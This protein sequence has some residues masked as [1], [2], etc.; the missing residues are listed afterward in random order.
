MAR[1]VLIDDEERLLQTLA[2][3]LEND[4]HEVTRGTSF[5]QVSDQLYPGRFEVLVTDIVMPEFDGM[6]VLREVVEARGCQEPVCLITGEPNLETAS[7]AVRRGAFDYISKPVTKDKL[8]EAVSRGLRHVQLLRER[9]SAL[10]SEMDVLRNLAR[11]GESASVLSH[12]IRTPITSLRQ[13]L[14]AVGQ[15]L[16]VEDKVLIEELLVNLVKIETMLG[17]TLSLVKP[18]Q[19]ARRATDIRTLAEQ[20]ARTV[21]SLPGMSDLSVDLD[22]PERL[23]AIVDPDLFAEVLVNLMRNAGE[24]CNGRGHIEIHATVTESGL[25]LEVTDDGPGVPSHLRDEIFRPFRSF[26]EYGTGIGLAFSRKVVESHGG[27]IRFVDKPGV[28]ACFRI[29]IAES[30]ARPARPSGTVEVSHD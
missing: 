13:A 7:E 19:L 1:I 23:D 24:A 12:E 10:R 20:C 30:R 2:R 26:K 22:M 11:L 16:G 14:R 5:A 25:A 18:L 17:K 8:F 27:T 9:D 28:G 3:F 29:E 15:K 6:H 4:G 21:C